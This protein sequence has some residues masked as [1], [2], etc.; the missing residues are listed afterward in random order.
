MKAIGGIWD[1]RLRHYWVP[2]GSVAERR[3]LEAH[4]PYWRKPVMEHS[5]HQYPV[6]PPLHLSSSPAIAPSYAH[7]PAPAPSHQFI[8]RPV[9]QQPVQQRLWGS[10]HSVQQRI[11]GSHHSVLD[12]DCQYCGKVV[13][14]GIV[15][16]AK[17]THISCASCKVL[18]PTVGK[19]YVSI[20]FDGNDPSTKMGVNLLK[21]KTPELL[22]DGLYGPIPFKSTDTEVEK[23][24]LSLIFAHKNALH[25]AG[26]PNTCLVP[27]GHIEELE[28]NLICHKHSIDRSLFQIRE[29]LV[30]KRSKRD[31][32]DYYSW[33]HDYLARHAT[34]DKLKARY[35][36]AVKTCRKARKMMEDEGKTIHEV[37]KMNIPQL[38]LP[39]RV[40]FNFENEELQQQQL[41]ELKSAAVLAFPFEPFSAVRDRW[42]ATTHL[43]DQLK[44]LLTKS[45]ASSSSSSSSTVPVIPP[46]LFSKTMR[47]HLRAEGKNLHFSWVSHGKFE[48]EV[49]DDEEYVCKHRL[50]QEITYIVKISLSRVRN[51]EDD[52]DEDDVEEEK[53]EVEVE[54]KT[55]S[56]A[57]DGRKRQR[58]G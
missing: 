3:L 36:E 5:H 50:Q 11:W 52:D 12:Q 37:L 57:R 14:V 10:H 34:L 28:F 33:F 48:T 9:Q 4:F 40:T 55:S 15:P 43:G 27:F 22:Y 2:L 1:P 44:K 18:E 16:P 17:R 35:Y 30:A 6:I 41:P 47:R 29:M 45:N 53:E 24:L 13:Q 20:G 19:H 46:A 49:K 58:V 56:S 21:I 31:Q 42:F 8:H 25:A 23:R 7:A 39:I 54:T 32:D 51:I 26:G 38:A